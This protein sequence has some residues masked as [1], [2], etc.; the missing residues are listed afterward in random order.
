MTFERNSWSFSIRSSS[1]SELAISSSS[2]NSS[3]SFPKFIVVDVVGIVVGFMMD[4]SVVVSIAG[5]QKM[6]KNWQKLSS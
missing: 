5:A 4:I 6:M 1:F 3:S 2:S